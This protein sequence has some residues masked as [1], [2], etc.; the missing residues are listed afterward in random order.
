[1][2]ELNFTVPILYLQIMIHTWQCH[3]CIILLSVSN[4]HKKSN[5]I[6]LWKFCGAWWTASM[7]CFA[8]SP[9]LKCFSILCTTLQMI[10]TC[11]TIKLVLL[12][13]WS[14]G[15]C[16]QVSHTHLN[17]PFTSHIRGMY[18]GR[19]QKS[20]FITDLHQDVCSSS[21][22]GATPA[23]SGHWYPACCTESTRGGAL[24]WVCRGAAEYLQEIYSAA[25]YLQRYMQVSSRGLQAVLKICRKTA[26]TGGSDLYQWHSTTQ[27]VWVWVSLKY[28]SACYVN[29]QL[30][31]E[32]GLINKTDEL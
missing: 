28:E 5:V 32:V 30:L 14:T 11:Q 4:G 9:S 19:R 27:K 29:C 25:G 26:G 18:V 15:G 16:K 24:Q 22:Q 8:F 23:A 20:V 1:M 3:T 2:K 13:L 10:H 6:K 31:N 7:F 17:I 12:L 21:S